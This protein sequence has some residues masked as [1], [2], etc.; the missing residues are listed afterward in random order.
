MPPCDRAL[1]HSEWSMTL[2]DRGFEHSECSASPPRPAFEVCETR[3]EVAGKRNSTRTRGE[4]R[5]FKNSQQLRSPPPDV[6][7]ER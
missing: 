7:D 4:L 6:P 1:E 3:A 2:C 5:L